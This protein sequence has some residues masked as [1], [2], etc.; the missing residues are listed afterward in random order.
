MRYTAQSLMLL[1]LLGGVS[2]LGAAQQWAEDK[3]ATIV[4]K[5]KE[6]K[7]SPSSAVAKA[8]TT[9]PQDSAAQQ[10]S[11]D[12]KKT[13]VPLS[14][15]GQA[16]MD[17][18]TWAF[19]M[20]KAGEAQA[21]EITQIDHYPYT[22]QFYQ[23]RYIIEAHAQ[24]QDTFSTPEE[25]MVSRISAM[26]NADYSAWLAAWD[27]PSRIATEKMQE[28]H[29]ITPESQLAMWKATFDK[30]RLTLARRVVTGPY[31]IVTYYL[32]S[33]GQPIYSAEFPSIFHQVDGQ[34][35]ATQDLTQDPLPAISPWSKGQT[36]TEL[37]V[38][39]LQKEQKAVSQ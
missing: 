7:Q 26:M 29:H 39:P 31:V 25:A 32:T 19:P 3:S 14:E 20:F 33:N 5:G 11:E 15:R 1:T 6:K 34:W 16:I 28:Q 35:Y 4:S 9:F 37:D 10:A 13:D 30:A 22:E 24:S 23:P 36:R 38:R 18:T 8:P 2:S 12:T 17:H 27:K 21:K